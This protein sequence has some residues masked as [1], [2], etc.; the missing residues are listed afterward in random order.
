M[1]NL[2]FVATTV[3]GC[4]RRSLPR[5]VGHP[6]KLAFGKAT[7]DPRQ[8]RPSLAP[9]SRNQV[10]STVPQSEYGWFSK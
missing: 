1:L 8:P 2:F 3:L 6:P 9:T 10:K 4:S 5:S 7:A